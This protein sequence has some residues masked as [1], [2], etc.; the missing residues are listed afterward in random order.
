LQSSQAYMRKISLGSALPIRLGAGSLS[1]LAHLGRAGVFLAQMLYHSAA[2][3]LKIRLAMRQVW[4]I[5]WKSTLVNCLMGMFTGMVLALQAY[6]ALRQVGS[7]GYL[8]AL[9]SVSLVRELG[10]VLSS[11]LLAG[12]AGSS[13]AAEI[14]ILRSNEQIDALELMGLSPFRY[15][16]VPNFV[17]FLLASPLLAAMFDTTGILGGYLVGVK[18]FGLN[19]GTY[20]GQMGSYDAMRDIVGGLWKSLSFG[21]LTAWVCCY[22]GYYAAPGAKGVS[23][24]T[25]E[26]VVSTSILIL[27]C[28]YLITALRF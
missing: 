27:V 11:L 3:P 6:P 26:A 14:G 24:A 13:V 23:A 16:V 12:R 28:D 7:E 9:V 10:P 19:A 5:G 1:L 2:S 18:L 20:F 17:A 22:K 21:L 4:F 25:T 8:G 15:L